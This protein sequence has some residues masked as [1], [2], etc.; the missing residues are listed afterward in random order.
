MQLSSEVTLTA[1]EVLM[2][3]VGLYDYVKRDNKVI[4]G[5]CDACFA[6]WNDNYNSYIFYFT[7]LYT[8]ECSKRTCFSFE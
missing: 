3:F 5:S 8:L 1:F 4:I 7:D 2:D 6:T